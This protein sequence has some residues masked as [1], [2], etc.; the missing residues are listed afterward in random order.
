MPLRFAPFAM[1]AAAVIARLAMTCQGMNK[2][3]WGSEHILNWMQSG[4]QRHSNVSTDDIQLW[5]WKL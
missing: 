5:M 2:E 4:D 1:Y 3:T